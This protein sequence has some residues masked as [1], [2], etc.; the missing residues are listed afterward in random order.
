M[1]ANDADTGSDG[2]I[3]YTI[4]TGNVDNQFEIDS[5][6]NIKLK[7]T[8]DREALPSFQL[9]LVVNDN[10]VTGTPK[11]ASVSI[12]IVVDDVNDNAPLFTVSKCEGFVSDDAPSLTK[13]LTVS[14]TDA[15]EGLNAEIDYTLLS[16]T[17]SFLD[18]FTFSADSF[19]VKSDLNLDR[20]DVLKMDFN[21]V[22]KAQD[23]GNPAKSNT[24]NCA[25]HVTGKNIYAPVLQH[26]QELTV[27]NNPKLTVG[28]QIAKI[29]ASDE[30]YGPDGE[31][32]Y[33]INNDVNSA[34]EISSTGVV[35]LKQAPTVGFY[36]LNIRISDKA[37]VA[38]Q[39]SVN[40]TLLVYFKQ[41]PIE[42]VRSM[43]IGK[44][45]DEHV[46]VAKDMTVKLPVYVQLGTQYLE[47]ID[48][49]IE[50]YGDKIVLDSVTSDFEIITLSSLKIK[51]IG[52][53]HPDAQVFGYAKV[54]DVQVTGKE[55]GRL[56]STMTVLHLVDKEM[57]TIPESSAKVSESCLHQPYFVN[58]DCS[59]DILDASFI[60]TYVREK[61]AKFSN[62]LGKQLKSVKASQLS[63]M[64]SDKNDRVDY[65]DARF[66]LNVLLGRALAITD[67]TVMGPGDLLKNKENCSLHISAAL[68][69]LSLDAN[70]D[71]QGVYIL[72]TYP[73]AS[74]RNQLKNTFIV[75]ESSYI[76][77]VSSDVKYGDFVS[78]KQSGTSYVM[79]S[80][81][82]QISMN[83]IG[84]SLL[85]TSAA[86]IVTTFMKPK[87]NNS[88]QRIEFKE[89]S[90][91]FDSTVS[92]Q[93]NVNIGKTSHRCRNPFKTTRM[94]IKLDGKY[95]QVVLFREA[96]FKAEIKTYITGHFKRTLNKDLQVNI[97][98]VE[99]GSVVVGFDVIHEAED[100]DTITNQL[101]T[102]L[103]N[104]DFVFPFN[105]NSL[106]AYNTL[107]VNGEDRTVPEQEE[108]D[109][110]VTYIIIVVLILVSLLFAVLLFY[111]FF[112]K[113]DR[114]KKKDKVVEKKEWR[115]SSLD[116]GSENWHY[117]K[118]PA[119][120]SSYNRGFSDETL[121]VVGGSLRRNIV[122]ES[123]SYEEVIGGKLEYVAPVTPVHKIRSSLRRRNT[124]RS[125][126]QLE[127][128]ESVMDIAPT[129]VWFLIFCCLYLPG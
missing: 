42:N 87:T 22:V 103:R 70:S 52:L 45:S 85:F 61:E 126:A 23:K 58:N 94:V 88:P 8:L 33:K 82:S 89:S 114:S 129:Q 47:G 118:Q 91:T 63:A 25:I 39:K 18:F 11:Q 46:W 77:P 100:T 43:R 123:G 75:S 21:V 28:S 76:L 29:N 38:K 64:D 92:A 111:C 13:V 99:E 72:F 65:N 107:M 96:Q 32:T 20:H 35:T 56:E 4:E 51:V 104:G 105:G 125:L 78:I 116:E 112:K 6:G 24:L 69:S 1:I 90:L 31:L 34:F 81:V 117:E 80:A 83:N 62:D 108:N 97:V 73:D 71:V 101:S 50:F 54:A 16:S 79:K 17:D 120:S 110:T 12:N 127:A 10:P 59:Y 30:D 66:V 44:I 60:Q 98:S 74:L 57:K 55:A 93:V 86:G 109:K 84:V 121:S 124:P 49:N 119:M 67:Y 128:M 41:L 122:M 106:P 9:K 2:E 53:T 5:S 7:K 26:H 48:V 102:S 19:I 3:T 68:K 27:I 113:K 37:S 115:K 36:S 95:E 40:A 15:D 14:A